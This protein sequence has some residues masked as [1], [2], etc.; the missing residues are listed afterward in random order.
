MLRP[1]FMR[2][3]TVRAEVETYKAALQR[4]V[5]LTSLRGTARAVGISPTALLNL[6]RGKSRPYAGTLHKLREWYARSRATS[7]D[8]GV[9]PES[10]LAATEILLHGVPGLRRPD[11]DTEL[12]RLLAKLHGTRRRPEWLRELRSRLKRRDG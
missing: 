7:L 8:A 11:A 1:Y 12:L 5:E 3:A 2:T 10:A 4:E 9:T 6:V